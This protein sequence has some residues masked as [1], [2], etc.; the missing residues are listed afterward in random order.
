MVEVSLADAE[1][2]LI[3]VLRGNDLGGYTVPTRGLYPF[4]WNWDAGFTALGW[5]A[6][7][8]PRAWRELT[9]LLD[10]QWDDGMIPHIVF[11]AASAEYFPGPDVWGVGGEP[12][13]SGITQPPVLGFV[14]ADMLARARDR[15]LAEARI[16]ALYPA[17]LGNLRWWRDARTVDGLA[18]CYHPWETGMDNSPAWDEP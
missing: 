3:D 2:R 15:A 6:F 13:T 18:L 7:D 12:P 10:G 16:A 9:R 11:H 5:A 8:E 1:S 17:L 14:V 4:Q